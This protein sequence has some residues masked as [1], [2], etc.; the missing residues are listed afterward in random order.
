LLKSGAEDLFRRRRGLLDGFQTQLRWTAG[1]IVQWVENE[2][3]RTRLRS[4]LVAKIKE[5][6]PQVICGHSLGSLV[7]YDTFTH[8]A[9]RKLVA[10]RSFVSLGSQI[11]N[12]FVAG[13][14][15][16]GRITPLSGSQW[17]HL[18]NSHDHVFTAPIRLSD[19]SFK[20]VETTFDIDGW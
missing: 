16:A 7:G 20:S 11:A 1:M 10:G 19:P 15:L 3:L 4:G 5:F 13:N 17:Y 2:E 14:F 9:T 8:P 18:F 12:P 6:D